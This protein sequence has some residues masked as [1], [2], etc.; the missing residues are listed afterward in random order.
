M[1][2]DQTIGW[3][4]F[5]WGGVLRGV[6]GYLSSG[7]NMEEALVKWNFLVKREGKKRKGKWDKLLEGVGLGLAGLLPWTTRFNL[8]LVQVCSKGDV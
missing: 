6:P 2:T 8:R 3:V 7:S 1:S 5:Q 4:T